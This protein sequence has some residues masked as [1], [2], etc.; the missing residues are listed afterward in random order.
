MSISNQLKYVG[1]RILKCYYFAS[2][3]ALKLFNLYVNVLEIMND[4]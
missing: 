2:E 3:I 1:T 4:L